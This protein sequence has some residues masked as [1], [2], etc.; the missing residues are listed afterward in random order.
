LIGLKYQIGFNN[1][2]TEYP[3]IHYIIVMKDVFS[4]TGGHFIADKLYQQKMSLEKDDFQPIYPGNRYIRQQDLF[5]VWH[6]GNK[7]KKTSFIDLKIALREKNCYEFPIKNVYDLKEDNI[8]DLVNYNE[9]E[10]KAIYNF[11]KVTIGHTDNPL[12][13][14]KNKLKLRFEAS[15]QYNVDCTNCSNV[16]MGQNILLSS[17]SELIKKPYNEVKKITGPI[18]DFL[19]LDLCIPSFVDLK[20]LEMNCILKKFKNTIIDNKRKFEESVYFHNIALNYGLGGIHGCTESGVYKSDSERIIIDEDIT[21]FFPSM[22]VGLGVYPKHLGTE[23]LWAYKVLLLQRVEEKKKDNGDQNLIEMLKYGC[24]SIIGKSN[25][26]DS[27]FYDPLFYHSVT[28]AGQLLMSMWIER[29]VEHIPNIKILQVNTDGISYLIN[30]ND[31]VKAVQIKSEISKIGKVEIVSEMYDKLIIKDINNYIA[32][33]PDHKKDNPHYKTRGC[34]EVY[35][36][37]YL[38]PS[39]PIVAK[40]LIEYFCNGIPIENTINGCDD[41]FDFC[42]RVRATKKYENKQIV[43]DSAGTYNIGLPDSNRIYVSNHGS[44]IYRKERESDKTEPI[45]PNRYVTIFNDAVLMKSVKSYDIDYNYYITEARKIK[46]IIETNQL[47]L[48]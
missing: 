38:D 24:N 19:P 2:D 43:F 33:Y 16:R 18:V 35:K 29:L 15:K 6:F 13:K 48:F 22:A 37:L 34:F 7:K 23:F 39:M 44:Y 45:I 26:E 32:V 42:I 28:I 17:Y 10:V 47:S 27:V 3:I 1:L 30:R 9:E 5:K 25:E 40:S 8:I 11:Y 4:N 36:E 21:S 14:G 46:D 41:I 20:T 12:F 31:I